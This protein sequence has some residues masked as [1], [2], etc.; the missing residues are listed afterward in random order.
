MNDEEKYDE[1]E[2]EN[3]DEDIGQEE[4]IQS[5]FDPK[6][7]KITIEPNTVYGLVQRM[8]FENIDMNT[9]FQRKGNLWSAP[10]QSRLIE[11]L[12]LRF[13]LPAF[14]FDATDDNKWLVVDGLQRL[15]SLKNFILEKKNPLTTQGLEI[16]T[17]K[18]FSGKTYKDLSPT[19]KRRILETPVTTYLI[20]PGTPK[21]VKYNVFRRIN[22]SALTLTP[23]EIRHALNQGQAADYLRD[24]TESKEFRSYIRVRDNRMQD[25]ELVLRYLAYMLVDYRKYE[26]PMASFLDR[27]MEELNNLPKLKLEELGKDL[28]R[29]LQLSKQLFKENIFSRSI[30]EENRR[31]LNSALFEVWTTVLAKLSD[32]QHRLILD[33]K[34]EIISEFKGKLISDKEFKNAVSS[35]TSG[36]SAVFKRFETIETLI[37][38]YIE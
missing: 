35:A 2:S 24:I 36:K 23:Q 5:P 12:L 6:K 14:Y 25:R 11:S 20:Q 4:D 9:E 10:V 17:N 1:L 31:M 13:P 16:L 33:H 3:F 19:F 30:A 18:D 7:I 8:K 37:K 29:S 28:F 34:N 26:K 21:D 32:K 15:W 27:R 38:K 22:T